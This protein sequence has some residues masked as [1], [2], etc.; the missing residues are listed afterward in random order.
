MRELE[1]SYI[2]K[3]KAEKAEQMQEQDVQIFAERIAPVMAEAQA[4]LDT[5]GDTSISVAGI[6]ALARWKLGGP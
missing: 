3:K 6:E 5:T 2:E 4:L 1:K